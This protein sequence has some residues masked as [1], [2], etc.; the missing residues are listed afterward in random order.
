[1]P[2]T[3]RQARQDDTASPG[4]AFSRLVCIRCEAT[5]PLE[6]I[7]YRCACGGLLE[8]RHDLERLAALHDAQ[9]WK[10][11]FAERL[12]SLAGPHASGVWRYHE[13]VLPDLPARDVITLYEGHTGLHPM[14]GLRRR[15]RSGPLHVKH[16]GEN[17]T[18]SFKDRGMTAGVS[19]A[20]HLGVAAVAC[21]STG[22]TSAAL[23]AYAARV[24]GLGALVVVPR[25][26]I[27]P[28]QL[29]QPIA[30]GARTI[31]LNTDFDGCIRLLEQ[32]AARHGLYIL[33]S[34]NSIRLEG[35]KTIAFEMLQQLGWEP[36]DWVVV[37][38]GN[39]GNV[40][41][42]AKGLFE[43]RELGLISRVPRVAGV[44]VEAAAPLARAFREGRDSVEPVR[45]APTQASAIRIGDPVSAPKALAAV[46]RSAG[47]VIE[48]S[49]SAMMDAKAL[50]DASGV[51]ICPNSGVAVAGW[52][53]LVE[54]GTIGRQESAVVVATAHGIKFSEATLAYHLGD[55][56]GTRGAHV[57]PPV[58]A[59]ATLE[60]LERAAGMQA[61]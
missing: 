51:S 45:A 23:A 25:D 57:N 24:D 58:E 61:P 50:V 46:R 16:E 43:L 21:A 12:T 31:R 49:E 56:A 8:V 55:R 28:E 14:P 3:A 29:S 52:I 32:L 37:P 19:W 36:P 4:V 20:R 44:Q 38:V 42:I 6:E 10:R 9:A 1:M 47:V 18:L 33:N 27:T 7:R 22:D 15:L 34:L 2:G 26:G 30:S 41:A 48:V 60:A 13:L 39:A 11:L 35:Q 5:H 53:Q 40:S 54:E 17:P 59:E